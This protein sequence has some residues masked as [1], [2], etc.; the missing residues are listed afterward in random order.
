MSLDLKLIIAR[1]ASAAF[2]SAFLALITT[3]VMEHPKFN[4]KRWATYEWWFQFF[5]AIALFA[6]VVFVSALL[7]RLT[8]IAL[9]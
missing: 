5:T 2:I 9:A 1:S 8:Q 3:L 6:V 7:G 4:R